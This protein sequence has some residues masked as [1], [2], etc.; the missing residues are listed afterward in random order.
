MRYLKMAKK[1]QSFKLDSKAKTITLYT[2]V[3]QN[4]TEKAL[5]EFY[6]MQGYTPLFEAKKKGVSVADMRKALAED[7]T[8]LEEFNKLYKEKNGFHDACR[9]YTEF[10]KQKRAAEKESK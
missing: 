2:N 1:P 7:E 10:M 8:K 3:E 5:I 6:L 4:E 9:V